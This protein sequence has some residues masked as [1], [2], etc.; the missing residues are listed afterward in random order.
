MTNELMDQLVKHYY[1]EHRDFLDEKTLAMKAS[2]FIEGYGYAL[3]MMG[4]DGEN[5]TREAARKTLRQM[6]R[7][8]ML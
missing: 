4:L 6:K 5:P 3:T 1:E 2:A 8:R 7:E